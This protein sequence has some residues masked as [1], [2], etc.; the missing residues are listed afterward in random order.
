MEPTKAVSEANEEFKFQE[1]DLSSSSLDSF[2]A[3]KLSF[4]KKKNRKKRCNFKYKPKYGKLN[5]QLNKLK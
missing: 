1:N 5:I 2:E 3:I 4:V